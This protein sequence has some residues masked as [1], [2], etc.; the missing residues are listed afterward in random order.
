MSG[1]LRLR[2]RDRGQ[3]LRSLIAD[4]RRNDHGAVDGRTDHAAAIIKRVFLTSLINLIVPIIVVGYLLSGKE[5]LA[6][7]G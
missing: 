1:R 2:D 7:S 6:L 3:C 4:R 5:L